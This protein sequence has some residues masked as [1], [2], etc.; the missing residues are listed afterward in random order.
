MIFFLEEVKIEIIGLGEGVLFFF[1][2]VIE[3]VKEDLLRY[4][5]EL[6]SGFFFRVEKVVIDG[7]L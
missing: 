5:G 6:F 4:F 7:I 1:V 3:D 2:E